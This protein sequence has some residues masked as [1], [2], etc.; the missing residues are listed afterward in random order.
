MCTEITVLNMSDTISPEHE[1]REEM[2]VKF[3]V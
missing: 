1:T 2:V 3:A